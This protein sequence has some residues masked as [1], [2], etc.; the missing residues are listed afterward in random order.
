[1]RDAGASKDS[2]ISIHVPNK[3]TTSRF[4]ESRILYCI[5]IHVPNKGTTTF[6]GTNNTAQSIISIHVPNKG[7]T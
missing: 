2:I 6:N 3:G 7:T 4:L 1:M 5:S